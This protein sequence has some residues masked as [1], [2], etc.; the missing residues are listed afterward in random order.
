MTRPLQLERLEPRHML[1]GLADWAAQYPDEAIVAKK[2]GGM[3]CPGSGAYVRNVDNAGGRD[4]FIMTLAEDENGRRADYWCADYS[5]HQ[6]LTLVYADA[7]DTEDNVAGRCRVRNGYNTV[8]WIYLP[9]KNG[10][11]AELL[12][13]RHAIQGSNSSTIRQWDD[14]V[15]KTPIYAKSYFHANVWEY[16]FRSDLVTFKQLRGNYDSDTVVTET[17]PH[18]PPIASRVNWDS[19][20]L[21]ETDPQPQSTPYHETFDS[22]PTYA[23]Y[24]VGDF[25][26]VQVVDGKLRLDSIVR[27]TYATTSVT[28]TLEGVPENSYVLGQFASLSDESHSEDGVW[29]NGV[30]RVPRPGLWS[31][32]VP[33]GDVVI[34][35]Q[36]RDNYPAPIDGHEWDW[37]KVEAVSPPAPQHGTMT[38]VYH[39]TFDTALTREDGWEFD[40]NVAFV[41]GALQLANATS[42][43]YQTN[44]ATLSLAFEPRTL[45]MKTRN[46]NDER[47]AQ[48]A[49]FAYTDQWVRVG[50]WDDLIIDLPTGTSRI[51]FDQHDN[52]DANYDG[53][54]LLGLYLL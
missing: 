14:P 13:T 19:I 3:R 51:R 54:Q 9:D 52:Y 8:H 22:F 35:L 16:D 37:I 49:I 41:G 4:R 46:L 7:D 44:S 18:K 26:R 40:G 53:R 29:I 43:S 20:E 6:F 36:Q 45:I 21:P 48:D 50:D 25:G 1:S 28:I 11:V 39:Q 34:T 27:G 15:T 23:S 31:V 47:H 38:E 5:G 42:G 17:I 24:D 30:R 2:P 32:D 33:S 12:G 10:N